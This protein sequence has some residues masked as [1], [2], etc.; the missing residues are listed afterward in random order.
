MYHATC[1]TAGD[2]GN[3]Y[4]GQLQPITNGIVGITANL[5]D[6]ITP[7]TDTES[8][9]ALRQRFDVKAQ[10]PV[11]SGNANHYIQ[12]ALEVPGTGAAK[13]IPLDTGPGTVTVLVVDDKKSDIQR[14]CA[15]SAVLY[16]YGT[17]YWGYGNSTI[18]TGSWESM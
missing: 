16:R 4:S 12:W 18:A 7:G 2:K 14:N 8:D 1:T 13:A 11:T 3:Q 10:L 5:T 9:E 17:P 15:K 6:I